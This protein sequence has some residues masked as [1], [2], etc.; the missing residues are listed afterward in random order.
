M[1]RHVY[2]DEVPSVYIE[3]SIP[4][5]YYET[6]RS[7]SVVAWKEATRLWW[8]RCRHRYD[9][10]TS[11]LTLNEVAAGP[12]R[13]AEQMLALIRDVRVLD[14]LPGTAELIDFYVDH[15]L[16]P[17]GAGGD[18]GHLAFASM[19]GVDF[20]LTWNCAHLANANKTKHL[21]VLNGRLGL[22]VPILTTPLTL[23]PE[24]MPDEEGRPPKS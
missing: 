17:S 20:L 19:H 15:R 11:V 24:D 23:I 22:S 10:C 21:S 6:R 1:R 16:M 2:T 18:A 13:K 8:D 14:S 7:A 9:L 4:S 3:S 5:Y 12:P